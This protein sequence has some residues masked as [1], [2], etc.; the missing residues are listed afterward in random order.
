MKYLQTYNENIT[1]YLKPKSREE[2]ENALKN[3][4]TPLFWPNGYTEKQAKSLIIDHSNEFN[5]NF[6]EIGEIPPHI[7]I[8]NSEPY[9][10]MV[11]WIYRWIIPGETEPDLELSLSLQNDIYWISFT[12]NRKYS[13]KRIKR[14]ITS[15]GRDTKGTGELRF[16]KKFY[17]LDHALYF[18]KDCKIDTSGIIKT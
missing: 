3:D 16:R 5:K 6:S 9:I 12:D 10:P 15:G 7:K 11:K 1:Q 17:Y 2:V 8:S 18:L 14:F 4:K 13:P